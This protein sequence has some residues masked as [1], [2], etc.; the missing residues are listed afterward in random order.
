[1]QTL[2]ETEKLHLLPLAITGTHN[3]TCK[4]TTSWTNQ[5]SLPGICYN[6]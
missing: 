3:Y 1:M 4:N 5:P 2:V 6:V